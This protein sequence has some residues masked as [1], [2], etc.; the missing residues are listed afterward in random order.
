LD[1]RLS[2][3][4]VNWKVLERLI[5]TLFV[6]CFKDQNLSLLKRENI[7][8]R[9]VDALARGLEM[10]QMDLVIQVVKLLTFFSDDEV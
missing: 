3:D 2:E 5:Q 4:T 7:L 8:K 6:F 10:K 9:V 1:E